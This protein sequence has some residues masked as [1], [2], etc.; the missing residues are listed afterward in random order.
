L[1]T[2]DIDPTTIDSDDSEQMIGGC[3]KMLH[4]FKMIRNIASTDVPV[5]I[6]GASGTGKEKVAKAIHQRSIRAAGPFV[7]INCACIPCEFLESEL[8]GYEKDALKGAYRITKGKVEVAQGGTLF[9][10]EMGGLPLG[11]QV[12]LLLFLQ[13]HSLKR[14]GGR[15]PIQVNSRLIFATNINLKEAIRLG[16]FLKDL[17]YYLLDGVNIHLPPLKDRGDDVLV[18]AT[19]FLKRFSASMGQGIKCF[20]PET[21]KVLQAHTWPGNIRE[22]SIRIRRAVFMSDGLQVQPDHMG[23][24]FNSLDNESELEHIGPFILRLIEFSPEHHETGMT[25]L[26]YFGTVLR[27]KYPGMKVKVKIEQEDLMVRM[28]VQSEEGNIE[29]IERTLVDYGLVIKGEMPFDNFLSNPFEI[30]QLENQLKIANLQLENQKALLGLQN[31]LHG[32]RIAELED[33]VKWLRYHVGSI[34]ISSQNNLIAIEEVMRG[35]RKLLDSRD[36]ILESAISLIDK[37]LKEGISQDD[38][39]EL[40]Q[41]LETIQQRSPSFFEQFLDKINILIIQGSISGV[42]GNLLYDL[43]KSF[44]KIC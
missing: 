42:A 2:M 37:K 6:T 43:L 23:L 28:I 18:M 3:E 35:A 25:I 38:L 44:S 24:S 1:Q 9:L 41:A 12:K 36:E 19:V 22:L 31:S 16:T 21:V 30:L 33:E 32:K 13:E 7:A 27:Q 20:T 4:V 5:L 26:N 29:K 8:F 15:K 40:K 34:L 11:I 39:A 17:Y 14:I 10:D